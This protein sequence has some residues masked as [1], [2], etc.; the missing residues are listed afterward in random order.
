MVKKATPLAMLAA[1]MLSGICFAAEIPVKLPE[2]PRAWELTAEKELK[3]YLQR[4]LKSSL[5]ID[6]KEIKISSCSVMILCRR[7]AGFIFPKATR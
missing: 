7:R 2:S 3:D 4:S 5:I 6:G 1:A